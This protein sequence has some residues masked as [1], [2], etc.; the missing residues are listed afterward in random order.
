MGDGGGGG[1]R[2]LLPPSPRLRTATLA[3]IARLARACAFLLR[4]LTTARAL[5][6][7]LR[8]PPRTLR[9]LPPS[10][11]ILPAMSP[12][13]PSLLPTYL[14]ARTAT[15]L[16]SCAFRARA[17]HHAYQ[18]HSTDLRN[19]PT[20]AFLSTF[21]L[22]MLVVD[23]WLACFETVDGRLV[24]CV[25][26][27]RLRGGRCCAAFRF[28]SWFRLYSTTIP[29]HSACT[30]LLFRRHFSSMSCVGCDVGLV[31]F[32]GILSSALYNAYPYPC[33]FYVMTFSSVCLSCPLYLPLLPPHLPVAFPTHTFSLF[34][35]SLSLPPPLSHLL[36]MHFTHTHIEKQQVGG[37]LDRLG[38]SPFPFTH[39]HHRFTCIF[40]VYGVAHTFLPGTAWH[41]R[42]TGNSSRQN[43]RDSTWMDVPTTLHTHM[44][45]CCLRWVVGG[46]AV[47]GVVMPYMLLFFLPAF[48]RRRARRRRRQALFA[49][50]C[51]AALPAPR[52]HTIAH[53]AH[54]PTCIVRRLDQQQHDV[55]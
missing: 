18:C 8:T 5:R 21:A 26:F 4:A 41:G 31:G 43:K 24:L 34:S 51:T 40:V 37:R 11:V 17:C 7:A 14:C 13:Y 33:T 50:L 47:G 42:R 10:G 48:W 36:L 28:F 23:V 38:S 30:H 35:L 52:V 16:R 55:F 3:R 29:L 53:T 39:L 32:C 44:F 54:T 25:A 6:A 1:A 2:H 15:R 19:L 9:T 27:V 22:R 12:E 20:F 45:V 49:L 46:R